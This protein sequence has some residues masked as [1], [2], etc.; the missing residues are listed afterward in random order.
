[1]HGHLQAQFGQHLLRGELEYA[2]ERALQLGH[3]KSGD[4]HQG[5]HAYVLGVVNVQV[6][7]RQ[8]QFFVLG[9]VAFLRIQITRDAD[10]ALHFAI[11][12]Q[13]PFAGEAPTRFAVGKQVQFQ[14]IFDGFAG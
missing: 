9:V 1:M 12:T 6:A 8:P 5:L 10:D 3:G 14:H 13:W 7:Q 4:I 2:A 11:G